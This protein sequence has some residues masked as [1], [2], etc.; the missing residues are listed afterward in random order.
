[1]SA[2]PNQLSNEHQQERSQQPIKNSG[3]ILKDSSPQSS[4][5]A[6]AE[7]VTVSKT[8]NVASREIPPE[9]FLEMGHTKEQWQ[10]LTQHF[11]PNAK[12]I[13]SIWLV[14]KICKAKGLDPLSRPYHIVPMYD[15]KVQDYVDTIW[16]GVGLYDIQASRSGSYAGK[17]PAQYG[18]NKKFSFPPS[19]IGR[20][21]GGKEIVIESP[22][23]CTVTI[24]KMVDGQRVPY[25]SDP[26]YF[27]E[28]VQVVKGSNA[29][30]GQPND[31]WRT[32]F[33]SQMA[34]CARASILRS[35]FPEFTGAEATA[36][37]M[38]GRD[39]YP[40]YEPTTKDTR[41]LAQKIAS[42]RIPEQSINVKD[43]DV[44]T[45]D[46][47]LMPE[48]SNASTVVAPK[49]PVSINDT[50]A[51]AEAL[52][53]DAGKDHVAQ[54]IA[55]S[56]KN[57][58]RA[59]IQDNMRLVKTGGQHGWPTAQVVELIVAKYGLDA[60]N[61]SKEITKDQVDEVIAHIE[62]NSRKKNDEAS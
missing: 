61:W 23:W 42:E 3:E 12:S 2:I 45:I 9:A 4:S 16:P 49:I 52:A 53:R 17:D 36:E 47:D 26:I 25:T 28:Y 15:T 60:K 40:D 5:I 54:A 43:D 7:L 13:N 8:L 55:E 41:A 39:V 62:K 14:A 27:E 31:M 44:E 19:D 57:I 18:P 24:Y 51:A 6:G 21:K 1:M 11:F 34:K 35:T 20:Q 32:K 38:E 37:E 29:K 50:L 22:E 59:S 33:R 10:T 48:Q 56:A 46:A 30:A 58:A